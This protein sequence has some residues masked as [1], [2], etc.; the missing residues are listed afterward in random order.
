MSMR[1]SKSATVTSLIGACL[2]AGCHR[3]SAD[4]LP[5]GDRIDCAVGGAELA[6]AC[7]VVRGAGVVTIHH[8][9]G[10]FRRLVIDG[11]GNFS[12]ADGAD[13]AASTKRAD[14]GTEVQVGQDRYVIG[15]PGTGARS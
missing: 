2:V 11:R 15:K 1:T 5:A 7:T 4:E 12:A 10:G 8:P 6:N 9:D 3:A 14:G 13:V